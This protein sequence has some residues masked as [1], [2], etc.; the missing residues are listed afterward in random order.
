MALV[1]WSILPLDGH[2]FFVDFIPRYA[3]GKILTKKYGAPV[4]KTPTNHGHL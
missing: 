2:I 1:F 3:Q 4:V